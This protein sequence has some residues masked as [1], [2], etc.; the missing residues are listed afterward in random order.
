M[1]QETNFFSDLLKKLPSDMHLDI[2]YFFKCSLNNEDTSEAREMLLSRMEE[3]HGKEGVR[4][5]YLAFET[6]F[7]D[8]N[9]SSNET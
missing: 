9:G 3:R 6:I 2:A 1:P 5:L 4:K 8:H 7:L